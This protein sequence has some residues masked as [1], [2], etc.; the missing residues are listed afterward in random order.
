[1]QRLMAASIM[2]GGGGPRVYEEGQVKSVREGGREGG[3]GGEAGTKRLS[4]TSCV[5]NTKGTLN[6]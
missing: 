4:A 1:M 5:D 2:G 6:V 3:E